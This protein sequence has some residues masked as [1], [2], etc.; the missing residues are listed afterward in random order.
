LKRQLLRAR[1][2]HGAERAELLH[3]ITDYEDP[4]E[5][6]FYDNAGTLDRCSN[7]VHGYP[8]DFG[9]PF[10]PDTLTEGNRPSQR[11]MHYTQDE[12]QGVTLRY[13]GL[14][15]KSSYRIRFTL[16]RP[17]YQDRYRSRMNQ[18]TE[19]IYAG[20][21]VLARDL[22]IPERMSDFFTFDI[23]REAIRNGE[24]VIRF[25]RAPDVAHG[26]RLE[27]EIWRN[28]GGW[29]SIVSEA[30]LIKRP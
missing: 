10:V 13:R 7:I 19:S 18:R 4:G 28:T 21:I 14:D 9:Q 29:G 6:G 25:E 22:E 1:A 17:W 24:L 12:D 3:T 26:T 20:D 16:V 8:Y 27:R 15:P 5:G 2:A 30:W 23:P 11:T